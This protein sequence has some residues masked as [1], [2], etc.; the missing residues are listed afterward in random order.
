METG[1]DGGHGRSDF[2]HGDNVGVG[3]RERVLVA[4]LVHRLGLKSEGRM[5]EGQN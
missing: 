5:V 1:E 4:A 2:G 3:I